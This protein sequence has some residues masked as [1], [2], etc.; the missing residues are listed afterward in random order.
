MAWDDLKADTYRQY[1]RFSPLLLIKGAITRRTFRVV[2][3]M[4]LCQ[5]AAAS[6]GLFRFTLTPLKLLHRLATFQ[7]AMDLPWKAKIGAGLALTHGWGLVVNPRA[8]IGRNV[9]LFHGVTLGLRDRIGPNG[10]RMSEY[11]VIE[12]EVWIGPNA[13]I[14]G[15]VTIGRGSRIGGGAFVTES[16]PPYSMVLGNPGVVVKKDCAID[17]MNLAPV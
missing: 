17:V 7:A 1:G 12:D 8:T 11:P 13:I 15:G 5:A 14:A 10:E 2:V 9:T 3:T 4:R 6:K 16:V